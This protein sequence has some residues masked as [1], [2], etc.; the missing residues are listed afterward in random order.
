MSPRPAALSLTMISV[1]PT[2]GTRSRR[3]AP[4]NL[5]ISFSF[6]SSDRKTAAFRHRIRSK[7]L[8]HSSGN[9]SCWWKVALQG[10]LRAAAHLPR[11]VPLRVDA[12]DVGYQPLRPRVWPVV[13]RS[14]PD[15][16]PPRT[17]GEPGR[18]HVFL[19]RLPRPAHPSRA[20][21]VPGVP[22]HASSLRT[23]VIWRCT[24]CGLRPPSAGHA[25]RRHRA[26]ALFIADSPQQM[27]GMPRS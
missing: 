4:A 17:P 22:A 20:P 27:Y 9:K 21:R 11:L 25:S 6:A 24:A 26:R 1:A 19:A 8:S 7:P 12:A 16:P 15:I 14:P 18:P 3:R 5:V 10:T 13:H 2:N 23:G